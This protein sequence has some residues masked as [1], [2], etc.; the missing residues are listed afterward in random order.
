MSEKGFLLQ[1]RGR[2]SI[3]DSGPRNKENEGR[4]PKGKAESAAHAE[5]EDIIQVALEPVIFR[6]GVV[7]FVVREKV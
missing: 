5:K 7:A 3:E 2:K 1:G 4:A 6:S